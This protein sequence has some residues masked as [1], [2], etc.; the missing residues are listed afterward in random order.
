VDRIDC[1]KAFVRA[2]EGGS[3]SAAA[4]ELGLG[5]PAVSK[6]IALLEQEFGSQLFMRTTR[7]L[8]PTREAHRVYE[9]ARQ[10]LGTFEEAR[11]SIREAPVRP[12][13]ILR[14]SVPSSFGRHF[15][16]P[17]V[18]EYTRDYPDV[19]LDLRFDERTINLVEEGM[20]LALRIG[21]LE[22]SS[23]M[24]RRIGTVRRYLVASPQ[25]LKERGAPRNPDD[26]KDHQCITYAR[27]VLANQW[28][29]QSDDGRHVV[30]VSGAV[31]VDDADAMKEAVLQDLGIAVLPAWCAH[32]ALRRGQM[33]ALL[34]DYAVSSLPLHVVYPETHWMSARARSFLDFMIARAEVFS[35]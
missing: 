24:A 2:M 13:G 19:R 17:I 9:L 5:Q 23:L 4:K 33:K 10:V 22:S 32:E 15:L 25:Y 12:S 35:N 27:M 30:S 3:F 20:E 28:T 18:R 8:T 16:M 11:A 26:L 21:Q 7:K 31:M 14:I 34:P 29:F 6:R 1:L